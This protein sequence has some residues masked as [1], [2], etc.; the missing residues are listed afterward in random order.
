MF[1]GHAFLAFALA[2]GGARATGR[3]R[4]RAFALGATAALF[5]TVPDVD[6]AYALVGLVGVDGGALAAADRFW[7][8][9]TVVH[10]A[11]T[12]SLLLG[13]AV[14]AVAVLW[15]RRRLAGNALAVGCVAVAAAVSG[16]LGALVMALFVL[17][18]VAAGGVARG[19]DVRGRALAAAALLGVVTHPFGDLFTGTPPALLYPFDVTVFA[20]RV[21][22]F[23][24]PT[25]DLLLAF[26]VELAALWA[27]LLVAAAVAGYDPRA[28]LRWRAGAASPYALAAFLVPPPT[29]AVSYHFVFP[30]LALGALGA[31]VGPVDGPGR[32]PLLGRALT[33]LAAVTVAVGSYAVAYTLA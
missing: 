19:L 29:M 15:E 26:G 10:R 24:D 2:A 4:R 21:G 33:G 3:A 25:L 22:P 20:G 11:V 28:H 14:V 1:A 18:A 6:M 30:A 9:S 8:A 12:H 7:A 13:S 17:A 27:G 16:P 31:S 5:A 23:A 32:S